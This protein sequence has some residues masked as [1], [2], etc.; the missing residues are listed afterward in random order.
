MNRFRTTLVLA[1]LSL[2]TTLLAFATHP[3]P[4]PASF[5]QFAVY[6]TAEAGWKTELLLRNNL[7]S[8]S[9]TVTPALRTPDGTKTALPTVTINSNDVATVDLGSIIT[10]SAPQLTGAYGSIVFRYTATVPRALYAAV[11]VE[12]PGTPIEFHLD[13]YFQ[14]TGPVSG[15]Q[16]GIWWLPRDSVKDW[17]ILTNTSA[18]ALSGSL[19][20]YDPTGKAWNQP[21]RLSARQMMRVSVRSLL[22]EAGLTGTFGGIK[23]DVPNGAGYLDSAHFVYDET[24]GSL[25][26]MKMFTYDPNATLIQ[27]SLTD[28]QWTIRAPML[29]LT[30]PDPSLALPSGTTLQPAIFMRNVSGHAY[31]AQLTFNWRSD[32]NTGKSTTAVA[33]QPYAT[34]MVDVAA[35]QKNGTIPAPARWAYVSIT[36]PIQPDNLLAVATSFDATGRLGAQTAFSDQVASHWSGGK[37]EVD[38]NHDTIIAVGNA[39]SAASKAQITFYYNSGQGKYRIEQTLAT[40]EQLWLDMGKVIRNQVPDKNGNTIPSSVMSGTYELRSLT[41]KATQGL[42][43]GK[44]V[45]DKTYGYA[46]HGC[47]L[48]CGYSDP[49][50]YFDPFGLLGGDDGDQYVWAT[51]DC[52]GGDDDITEYFLNGTYRWWTGNTQIATASNNQITAVAVGSTTNNASGYM[53]ITREVGWGRPCPNVVEEPSGPVNVFSV[54]ITDADIENNDVDV[55]LSGPSGVSG[56]LEV[57]AN[58]VSNDPQVTANGGAALGPGS[59]QVPLNRPSMP[60]DIY[61]SVTASW[62][63]DPIPPSNTFGLSRTWW[64]QGYTEHTQYNT[65]AESTCTQTQGTGFIFNPSTCVFTQVSMSAQFI[66]QANRNGTGTADTSNHGLLKADLGQCSGSYP[67]GASSSNSFFQISSVTGT[68]NQV[69]SGSS[70]ATY[71]NPQTPGSPLELRRQFAGGQFLKRQRRR[72]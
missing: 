1:A 51:D 18:N 21:V 49:Y 32:S 37:W 36:A 30:N 70:V 66:S 62:N 25:A 44:L 14:A 16:E 12:L 52:E 19:T 2:S 17:L 71:P 5:E 31:T 53:P 45:I 63:V 50:M 13:G 55:T 65:P 24:N 20:L 72:L 56:T 58:G 26:L 38:A 40:D 39:G 48:C 59:Y 35:L 61:S 7:P 67:A 42:F 60:A 23:I 68:C 27:R 29:A 43:E 22:Q 47:M 54:E 10:T 34:A 41:N 11:M 8:Q 33:I 57:T 64:V 28:K 15:G 46:A 6:W 4:Q 3:A 9:L 69:L